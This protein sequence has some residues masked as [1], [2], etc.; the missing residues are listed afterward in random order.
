MRVATSA[1]TIAVGLTAAVLTCRMISRRRRRLPSS[2]FNLVPDKDL[3]SKLARDGYIALRG[4][5]SP[6]RLADGRN[7]CNSLVASIPLRVESGDLPVEWVMYDDPAVEATLKQV[8]QLRQHNAFFANLMEELRSVAAL[9]LGEPAL[10][11]NMQY[12]D[13]PPR[14]AYAAS[15][16]Y[17]SSRPTPPHQDG[18]YWCHKRGRESG[19]TMWLAV[20][21]A[22]ERNGCLRY[23][24][25]SAANGIRM[26]DFSAVLGFSQEVRSDRCSS[27]HAPP[28]S[29]Q[30]LHPP[31]SPHQSA[32]GTTALRLSSA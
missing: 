9:A 5:L 31:A 20:D 22:D 24:L 17:E 26:H 11:Q 25:G 12:F 32:Q 13:K 1:I 14:S 8:Q 18:F 19:V 28:R 6:Q 2:N 21:D 29:R 16:V 10:S 23:V 7:E 27:R 30:S 15:V 4:F 3:A